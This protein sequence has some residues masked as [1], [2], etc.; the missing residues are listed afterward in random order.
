[1]ARLNQKSPIAMQ[2]RSEES[3][4]GLPIWAKL[5]TKSRGVFLKML[6]LRKGGFHYGEIYA[7]RQ[8]RSQPIL[9][10]KTFVIEP[11][12]RTLVRWLPVE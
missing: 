10:T 4:A 9:R 12:L 8:R 11:S 1:M 6:R 3:I 5:G 7:P 2:P